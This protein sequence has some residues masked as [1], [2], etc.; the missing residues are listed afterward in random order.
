MA[1]ALDHPGAALRRDRSPALGVALHPHGEVA[2]AAVQALEVRVAATPDGGLML[3][4]SLVGDLAGIA[5][6]SAGRAG[7]ADGLWQH[8]CFEAFVALAG[9]PAYREFNFSPSGQWA[10]YAFSDYRRSAPGAEMP[11]SGP[12]ITV[13][14]LADRLEIAAFVPPALLPRTDPGACLELG[15]SAVV[16]A[17]GGE[18]SYWALAHTAERPDFHRRDAFIL[19]LPI[20]APRH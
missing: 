13:I 1:I 5:F 14:R 6:P 19:H 12:E 10:S 3:D 9:S 15:L 20:P 18:K 7:F 11:E 17:A 16:E 4:Y 2:C 8:T